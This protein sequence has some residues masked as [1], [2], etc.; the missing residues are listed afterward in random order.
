MQKAKGNVWKKRLKICHPLLL[1]DP[2][3]FVLTVKVYLPWWT[4]KLSPF[5]VAMIVA[6]NATFVDV[7]VQARTII[8]S[9]GETLIFGL[10]IERPFAMAF[11]HYT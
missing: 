7:V 9:T 8:C 6:T 3:I 2:P 4:E 10:K 11:L 1:P 5:G